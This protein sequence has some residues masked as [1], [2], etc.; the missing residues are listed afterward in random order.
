MAWGYFSRVLLDL[1]NRPFLPAWTTGAAERKS[2]IGSCFLLPLNQTL[3]AKFPPIDF[4]N[5]EI[6][7]SIAYA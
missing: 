3:I 4:L 1:M 6:Y 2:D 7:G 5:D